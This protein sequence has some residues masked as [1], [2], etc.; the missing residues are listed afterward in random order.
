MGKRG[1]R[2]P[3]THVAS[4]DVKDVSVKIDASLKRRYDGLATI[5]RA[6]KK[7]GASAFDAL[8]EAV[9]EIL[10]HEPPLYVV[11]GY[12]DA[13]EFFREELGETRRN[14]FR[15]VR[16]AKFASPREEEKYGTTKLD[17]AL[18]YLEAKLGAPLAHPPLPIAFDRLRIPV[19]SGTKGAK[20]TESLAAARVEDVVAATRALRKKERAP[21]SSFERLA[22]ATI[23]EH[24]S[25]ADVRVRVRGGLLSVTNVPVASLDAF[26]DL[27]ATLARD[28]PPSEPAKQKPK[29]AGK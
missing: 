18:S 13:A 11:A 16:V 29:A 15:F 22:K 27:V 1:S 17:A 19:A 8:W 28:K 6:S 14:G 23:A 2:G 24:P 25:L 10:E 9:G 4:V 3:A 12:R 26:R 5:I 20:R 7:R 21:T